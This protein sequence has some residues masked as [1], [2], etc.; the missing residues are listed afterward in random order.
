MRRNRKEEIKIFLSIIKQLIR[1][2]PNI[3]IEDITKLYNI[4]RRTFYRLWK[5]SPEGISPKKFLESLRLEMAKEF[6]SKRKKVKEVAN[7]LGF[8]E[9]GYFSK[10]FKKLTGV[11]PKT[12][13][14]NLESGTKL[15]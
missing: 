14:K 6:L 5:D 3:K 11:S 8:C 9:Q 2:E 1:Q 13:I 4:P 15:P 10:W 7:K 12:Y